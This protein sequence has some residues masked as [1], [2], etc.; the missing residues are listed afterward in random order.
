MTKINIVLKPVTKS[1]HIFLYQ[2]LEQRNFHEN[3]S[4]KKMPTF[5][6]HVKFVT[7]KP[8]SKWYII[9]YNDQ[10]VGS[11]YLTKINEIGIHIVKEIRRKNVA[12]SALK[13]LM[14]KNLRIRFLAN[15]NPKNKKS[16]EFFIKQNF[17]LIQYT[18]ELIPSNSNK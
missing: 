16:I 17:K 10:K 15:I 11:I 13:I 9:K 2:L 4:H 12:T 14:K 1:D 5:F 18:Y 6:Q 7:S 3:I 8:Y